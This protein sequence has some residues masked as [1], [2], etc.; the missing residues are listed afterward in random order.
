MQLISLELVESNRDS[1]RNA[2]E[3][4]LIERGQTREPQ[5]LNKKDET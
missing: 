4:Y 1:A 3:V 2:R 5:G